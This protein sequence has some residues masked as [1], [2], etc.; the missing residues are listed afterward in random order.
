MPVIIGRAE[1]ICAGNAN[2]VS[3][4][5]VARLKVAEE[6]VRDGFVIAVI[7]FVAA[8]YLLFA[9]H[10]EEIELMSEISQ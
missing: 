8:L 6:V 4:S 3:F 7:E 5:P 1:D 10:Q 2:F 9:R